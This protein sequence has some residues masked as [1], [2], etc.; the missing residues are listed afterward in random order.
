MP[1]LLL[2]SLAGAALAVSLAFAPAAQA[3]PKGIKVGMLTCNMSSGW[4]VIRA[5]RALWCTYYPAGGEKSESYIG[6]LASVGV[7]FGYRQEGK[8]VWAV[9][10]PSSDVRP[11]AL[12]GEYAG[13]TA[14]AT[15][16]LGLDANLL[17]G[18]MDRSIA[19]QPVSV[20]GNEG[21]DLAAGISRIRLA[22]SD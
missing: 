18:D 7:N 15:V 10:A 13:V 20:E 16:G 19:L 11:G 14:G 8:I 22:A 1:K 5:N 4:D 12:E 2:S 9:F 17:F 21:M 6:N 3:A